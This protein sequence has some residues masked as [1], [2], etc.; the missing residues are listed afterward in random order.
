MYLEDLQFC[1]IGNQRDTCSGDSEGPVIC[2]ENDNLSLFGTI[3]FGSQECA[4]LGE[5]SFFGRISGV[6]KWINN[7]IVGHGELF[8]IICTTDIIVKKC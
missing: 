7:T 2:L 6:H 4:K 1:A 8:S 5:A 3:S